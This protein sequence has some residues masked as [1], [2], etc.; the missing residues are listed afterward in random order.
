MGFKMKR[1]AFTMIELVIVIV[2]LGMLASLAIPR[3]ERDVRQEAG[4]N[5]LSAIRYTQHLALMD[6]KANVSAATAVNWQKAF[7]QIRFASSSGE[8][9]YVIASNNDYDTNLDQEEAALDPKNGKYMHS[10]DGT[11]DGDESSNIF[12]SHNYGIKNVDF[13]ACSGTTGSGGGTPTTTT[14]I[15][16]DYLGRLHK[17]IFGATDNMD[18]LMHANCTIKFEFESTNDLYIVIQQETGYAYIVDQN[19]S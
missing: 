3:L 10:S 15:A 9:Y 6:N 16:F 17:G 19:A 1:T 7:W 12:I 11:I 8:W 5:I 13:T 14:H 4:D 2:V 18:T